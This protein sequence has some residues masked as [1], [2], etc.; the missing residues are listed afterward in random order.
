MIVINRVKSSCNAYC[1]KNIFLC[2]L[3][4]AISFGCVTTRED[5]MDI[6]IGQ[7]KDNAPEIR[8][9]L[10]H[11]DDARNDAA[12]YMVKNMIGRYG[13]SGEGLDSI[14]N[15]FMEL[16]VN[17]VWN[18]DSTQLVRGNQFVS[19]PLH[20]IND[21]E[22]V[23]AEYLIGNIDDA[24][25]MKEVR[26]W[27]KDLS[28]E[29]F[30]ELLLPYRSGDEAISDWR[31]AYRSHYDSI[32]KSVNKARNSVEAAAIVSDAIGEVH[33]NNDL[34]IPHRRALSLLE[35][36]VGSCRDDCDRTIYAMRAFGVPVATDELIASPDNGSAHQWS[37]VYDNIDRVFRTF[38]NNRFPPTRDSIHNDF[39]RKGKV[40]RY[41]SAINTDRIDKFKGIDNPPAELLNPRHKDVTAEYFGHN[42]V[43]VPVQAA[44]RPVYLGVVMPE[45]YKPIDIAER[46]GKKAIF[47]DIEPEVIYFPIIPNDDDS[48]GFAVCGMPFMVKKDGSLHSFI[49]QCDKLNKMELNRKTAVWFHQKER[50]AY[51]VG[52]KMQLG[53]SESGPWH[54]IDSIDA[55]PGSNYYRIPLNNYNGE[56]YFRFLASEY[57]RCQLAEIIASTDSLAINRLPLTL[58]TD[59]PA[60]DRHILVDGDILG[61]VKYNKH[62]KPLI[63]RIDSEQR[64]GSLFVV[65]RNDDNFVVPGEEY[66]LMYFGKNGWQSLGR[67]VSEGFSIEFE[68]PDNAVLWL[69]NL[70]KGKEEQV[71]I[72]HGGKQLFNTNLKEIE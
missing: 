2:L 27:N 25:R 64:P 51:M 57:Q 29:Q 1:R 67:K 13:I 35:A 65:P 7:A 26:N 63:F 72:W 31:Q 68:A 43:A 16:P 53:H 52:C 32:A 71:F 38:D 4:I 14:E 70:T 6:A 54:D 40:Y 50:F 34:G 42:E 61:W 45:G 12:E 49:P 62:H 30:C 44:G 46:K 5:S 59:E 19:M 60:I 21:L 3:L 11:Y 10:T 47:R 58:V 48:S 56:R 9:V 18:F 36:P 20:R 22:T 37:V 24:W 41:T 28:M 39:R 69:R 8:K 33:Y 17:G 66:E 23:S 15:L 55:P